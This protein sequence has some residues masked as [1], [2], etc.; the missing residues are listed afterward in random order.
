[1]EGIAREGMT[2]TYRRQADELAR[3]MARGCS[4]REASAI[5]AR[6]AK[7]TRRRRTKPLRSTM[8]R[9]LLSLKGDPR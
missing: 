3:L 5:V 9:L 4:L 6:G 1:M 7:R 8:G 2:D